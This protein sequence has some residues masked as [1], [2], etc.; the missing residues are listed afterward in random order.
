MPYQPIPNTSVWLQGRE[1]VE[2]AEVLLDY[3]RLP[4]A[5]ILSALAIEIFLKSF[6]AIKDEYGKSKTASGH[7]LVNLYEKF[8]AQDN[9]DLIES[10]RQINPEVDILENLQKFDGTFTKFRYRYEP[11]GLYSVGSDIVYFARNLCDAIFLLGNV[12]GV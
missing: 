11:N 7:A 3:N 8:D 10:M 12:R 2:A 6:L 9:L 5:A 4:S 1:Y